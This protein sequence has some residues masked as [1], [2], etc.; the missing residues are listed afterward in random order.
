MQST[1]CISCKHFISGNY[2]KAFLPQRIPV[3]IQ[4]GWVMHIRPIEGDHGFQYEW[5]EYEAQKTDKT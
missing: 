2:C 5:V 1:Q 3:T 4:Q